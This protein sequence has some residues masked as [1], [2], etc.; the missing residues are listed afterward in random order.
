MLMTVKKTVNLGLVDV[1]YMSIFKDFDE[2]ATFG[3][4]MFHGRITDDFLH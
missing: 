1:S 2:T 4:D 3:K